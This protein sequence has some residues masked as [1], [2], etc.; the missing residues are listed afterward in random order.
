MFRKVAGACTE[1]GARSV[2]ALEARP[3]SSV[4]ALRGSALTVVRIGEHYRALGLREGDIIAWF[5][6]GTHEE[7]N[8]F[9]H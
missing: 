7:Y 2:R 8:R 9:R 6:I 5:W 4:A 1:A 3:T